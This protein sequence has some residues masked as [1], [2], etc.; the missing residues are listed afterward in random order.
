M[1]HNITNAFNN[2]RTQMLSVLPAM[3]TS[4]LTTWVAQRRGV[5]FPQFQG[6]GLLRSSNAPSFNQHGGRVPR[7]FQ[8]TM[9]VSNP[10]NTVIY[11]TTNG[12]IH[13]SCLRAASRRVR[14]Y[15]TR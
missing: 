14:R 1:N 12:L 5:I 2:M 11:F 13:A 15:G 7:N 6:Y 8:L 3:D 9:T 10:P 4:I